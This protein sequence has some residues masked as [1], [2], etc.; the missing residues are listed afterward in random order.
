MNLSLVSVRYAKALF[1]L[2]V[3]KG[4]TDDVY[5]DIKLLGSQFS[6]V[7]GFYEFVLSPVIKPSKKKELFEN[8][9]GKTLNPITLKF[10]S[11]VIDNNRENI[12]KSV[13]RDY[14]AFYK[15]SKGIKTATV[16]SAFEPDDAIRNKFKE[17]IEKEL[18]VKVELNVVVDPGLLGGFIL[19]VDD[20]M[21]DASILGKLKKVKEYLIQE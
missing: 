14:S 21:I 13:F 18:N 17:L 4:I 12:L 3:E 5:N 10:I 6:D 11:L 7:E 15:D 1:K 16:Y 8:V 20:K 9:F 19:K 2:G